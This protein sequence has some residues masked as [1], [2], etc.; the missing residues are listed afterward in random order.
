MAEKEELVRPATR[1]RGSQEAPERMRAVKM[2]VS[3]RGS[4]PSLER[5]RS[6]NVCIKCLQISK[7]RVVGDRN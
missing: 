2:N 6:I 4:A 3:R 5:T 1:S 7:G